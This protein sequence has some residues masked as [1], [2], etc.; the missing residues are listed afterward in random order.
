MGALSSAA[1]DEGEGAGDGTGSGAGATIGTPGG[2]MI[3][4][5]N[6]PPGKTSKLVNSFSV[7]E[8]HM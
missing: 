4:I 2:S 1:P 3:S 6:M 8:C 5:V 7:W